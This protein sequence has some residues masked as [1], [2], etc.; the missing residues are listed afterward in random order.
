MNKIKDNSNLDSIITYILLKK[1]A[2]PI[3]KSPAYLLELVNAS[4]RII[5][6]PS[7]DE[8][9]VALTILDEIVFWLK[10][11]LGGKI[12]QLNSFLYTLTSGN[13]FY[14]KLITVGS[15]EQR[16]EIIKIKKDVARLS[17]SLGY[18]T[19]DVMKIILREEIELQS[20][21]D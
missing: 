20:E 9:K 4:G 13:N 15:V 10:R 18:S 8:E 12:A 5:K 3:V 21:K 7:T 1:L 19:E 2:T 6:R 14:N 17:E 11:Q 16:A